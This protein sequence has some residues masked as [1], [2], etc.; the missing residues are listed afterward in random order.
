MLSSLLDHLASC[1]TSHHVVDRW[2]KALIESKFVDVSNDMP[3]S[4][5]ALKAGFI[6]KG[7]SLIVWRQLDDMNQ[8]GVR[9]VGAHTDSPGLHLKPCQGRVAAGQDMLDVEVY[10][11][12]LLSSWADR[13]L[14]VAGRALLRDGSSR[15]YASTDAVA[16]ISLLAIHL[17]RE[18]NDRGLILDRHLHLSA[19]WGQGGHG[20]IDWLADHLGV[21]S[22]DIVTWTGELNDSQTPALIGQSCEYVAS[23]KLDNQVS[24]WAAMSALLSSE[25]SRPS[26][27]ALFDHEEVGSDSTTGASGPLLEHVL[28]G[29]SN[30]SGGT[31]NEFLNMLS[32]SHCVSADS[33]HALHPNYPDRHHPLHAPVLNGG[34]VIKTNV[35][36]RYASS[37]ESIIPILKAFDRIG[38]SPQWF[39]SKNVIPCGST[40]GPLTATRLGIETVDIGIPQLSMHSIRETCGSADPESLR[41]LLA[42]YWRD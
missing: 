1:P 19:M 39:S 9:I 38:A 15:L 22:Q 17:D 32:R 27:V 34:V 33:S 35:G 36:Q 23:S 25:V 8:R 12:P 26:M 7:G 5:E 3:Y 13:D 40:I 18:V 42:A 6:R 16:R 41:T 4:P 28:E 14:R 11:G 37:A 29:L 21:N 24:C 2:V 10:G 20:F 31:R 30:A